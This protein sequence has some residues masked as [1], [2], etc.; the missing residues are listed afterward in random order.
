MGL[1]DAVPVPMIIFRILFIS[2][3][4]PKTSTLRC[5][6]PTTLFGLLAEKM[7]RRRED[8]SLLESFYSALNEMTVSHEYWMQETLG[9]RLEGLVHD[10]AS[11]QLRRNW[12]QQ[13]ASG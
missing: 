12:K 11:S 10:E 9:D 6:S 8:T 3:A 2:L 5:P 13:G 4:T 7:L 1:Y